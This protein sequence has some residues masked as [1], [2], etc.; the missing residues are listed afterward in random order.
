[1]FISIGSDIALARKIFDQPYSVYFGCVT[2]AYSQLGQHQPAQLLR[3]QRVP[4][5]VAV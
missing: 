2:V 3:E 5:H 1:M 4:E